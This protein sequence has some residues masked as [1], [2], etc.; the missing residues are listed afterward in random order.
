MSAGAA[1]KLVGMGF[2]FVD[3]FAGVGGFHAALES[4]GGECVFACE[5]DP[6]ARAVYESNWD[7]E[8]AHDIV[9]LTEPRV[10]VPPHDV[11]CAGFPCQPFSKS[12]KQLGMDE[13]RGTLFG[14]IARVIKKRE[15]S[16]VL[17]ENVRNIAG[18]RHLHEWD[19]ITRTLRALG[20]AVSEEPVVFSPHWLS[21]AAGGTPQVR[22]RV[23]IVAWKVGRRSAEQLR[24]IR[25]LISRGPV[26]SW[27]PGS[28]SLEVDLPL[29]RESEIA[30]VERYMLSDEEQNWIEVWNEFLQEAVGPEKL[31]GFPIWADHLVEQV[32]CELNTPQWKYDFLMK[33]ANFYRQ[34]RQG[35]NEWKSKHKNL[36]LLPASRKKLEW[37]AQD[38]DRDLWSHVLQFRPS[39]I[40]VK[41][42]TY[43]P[44]LVAIT[45]TSIIGSRKRRITPREAARLQGFPDW[46][47]FGEQ[48]DASTYRQLGNAVAVGAVRHV[49]Q[50]AFDTDPF[51]L[52]MRPEM[53]LGLR[54]RAFAA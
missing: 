48:P 7:M 33:N 43:L 41:R 37:Q 21:P 20:Y 51:K 22:E 36:E 12:G 2:T 18:P 24:G 15:P 17:L 53:L 50:R 31:P 14:N 46:F 35:I 34:H 1:A 5:I 26:D 45:Q 23:F 52:T 16:L 13:A 29:Q 38:S 8:V 9:P 10:K 27:D 54:E 28:W 32:D 19:V 11:L 25:P 30:N 44:A 4:L 3:L 47:S 40:R 39:G 6:A 42:A 49:F